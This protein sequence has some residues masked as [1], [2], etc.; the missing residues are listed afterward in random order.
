MDVLQ[1]GLYSDFLWSHNQVSASGC[2]QVFLLIEWRG[3]VLG[4]K[5]PAKGSKQL[6]ADQVQLHLQLGERVQLGRMYGCEGEMLNDRNLSLSLGTLSEGKVRRLVLDLSVGPR[7]SGVY[8]IV[9]MLWTYLDV[10]KQKMV[11]QPSRTIPLQFSNSTALIKRGADHRVEKALKLLQNPM[12]VEQ[13]RQEMQ[14]GK[15]AEG[16][17]IILRRADE[18]LLYAARLEDADYLKEA[19]ALYRLSTLYMDTYRKFRSRIAKRQGLKAYSD[20]SY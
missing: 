9:T 14:R 18:M 5:L 3:G 2:N 6:L 13:A 15:L 4:P 16:E 20:A 11:L 12:I 1:S 10:I 19:E 7:P 8:P 17:A